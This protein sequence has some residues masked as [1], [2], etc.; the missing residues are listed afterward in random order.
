[1]DESSANERVTIIDA[2]FSFQVSNDTFPLN[3]DNLSVLGY[4]PLTNWDK[5]HMTS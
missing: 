4:I 3:L 5:L 2:L 1:M